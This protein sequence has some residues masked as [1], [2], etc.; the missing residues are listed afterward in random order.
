MTT[1]DTI[2]N[3][4]MSI[5]E[6]LGEIKSDVKQVRE[7]SVDHSRRLSKLES[8]KTNNLKNAGIGGGAGITI[9]GL[10]LLLVELLKKLGLMG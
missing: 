3:H 1:N 8:T 9:G 6:D 7:C 4:L 10:M 5:K 2:I